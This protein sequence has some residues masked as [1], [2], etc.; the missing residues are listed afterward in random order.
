M[1]SDWHD[2]REDRLREVDLAL[3]HALQVNARAP[4]ARIAQ[5][6]GVDPATAARRWAAISE[7]G[8]AWFSV[9][10]TPE[11]H[12]SRADAASVLVAG[13]WS[14]A[15]LD[16]W[17]HT[18]WV[19]TIE[20]TSAGLQALVVGHGGLAALETRILD[21]FTRPGLTVRVEYAA[22][23]LREDST[24]R[25]P[26]LSQA[27]TKSLVDDPV[28][29]V[30][31]PR[32][33]VAEEISRLL[34]EDA[35]M[36]LGTIASRLGVADATARRSV[37]RVLGHGLVRVGCDVAMPAVGLGRGVVVRACSRED[38]D[39]APLLRTPQVHRVVHLV[40]PARWTV[41]CRVGS[42]ADVDHLE[43]SWGP[44]FEVVDR[45]TVTGA[46]KRNGH[47]LDE[48]GRSTGQVDVG[49]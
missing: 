17:C 34:G 7:A 45:W 35:R 41:S 48:S 36:S 28:T 44:G 42:L 32:D 37:E 8:T 4:W 43:R 31:P 26:V 11:R 15:D 23:V 18:P 29:G 33:E 2:P 24:W 25:L 5:V 13:A 46:L 3:V 9:W 22:A 14:E 10:P 19:L 49:W 39:L 16:L 20:R 38:F 27:Q 30:R 40:G 21:L 6:I 12:A 1:L 47:L